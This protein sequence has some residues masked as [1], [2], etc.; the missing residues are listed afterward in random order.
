MQRKNRVIAWI[1]L[2][3]FVWGAVH[4]AGAYLNYHRTDNPWRVAR[5]IVVL[6]SVE[7]FLAFWLVLLLWRRSR[8]E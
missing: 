6:L 1:V 2:A 5:A 3:V 7:G 8:Q 4:A